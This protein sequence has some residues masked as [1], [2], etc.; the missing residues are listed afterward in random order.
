MLEHEIATP[1][2]H[3][4]PSDYV[5]CRTFD[6]DLVLVDLMGGE[7]FALDSIGARM[8]ALLSAGKMPS[9]IAVILSSEY[10]ADEGT[11]LGDCR[12]LVRE[13]LARRLLVL[14]SP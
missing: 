9:E 4:A 10:Q 12:N 7:Y 11:I 5:R 13:L 14:R 2:R 3:V 6:D 1:D 8:W